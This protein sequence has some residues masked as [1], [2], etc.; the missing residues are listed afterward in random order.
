M[1]RLDRIH[2]SMASII[3]YILKA[4]ANSS[5]REMSRS[6]RIKRLQTQVPPP[7]SYHFDF[8]VGRDLSQLE[9]EE[10]KAH[11]TDT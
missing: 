8:R 6:I 9:L 7:K 1:K 11:F 4:D 5:H 2:K 10:R 3:I